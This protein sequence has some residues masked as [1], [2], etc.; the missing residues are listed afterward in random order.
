MNNS[1]L[2]PATPSPPFYV[3]GA[4]ARPLGAR[5]LSATGWLQC[6]RRPPC[7]VHLVSCYLLGL[8]QAAGRCTS[9]TPPHLPQS[10]PEHPP[11]PLPLHPGFNNRGQNSP[12]L[13]VRMCRRHISAHHAVISALGTLLQRQLFALACTLSAHPGAKSCRGPPDPST[14]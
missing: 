9:P 7:L 3:T 2:P 6:R 5:R 1:S 14:T 11:Q 10:A 12:L 13:S 8:C 4:A